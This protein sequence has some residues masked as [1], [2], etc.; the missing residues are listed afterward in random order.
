MS[1]WKVRL[2]KIVYCNVGLQTWWR[3]HQG[4][5]GHIIEI[6]KLNDVLIFFRSILV[7]SGRPQ[8]KTVD[9]RRIGIAW[10]KHCH[11]SVNCHAKSNN[12]NNSYIMVACPSISMSWKSSAVPYIQL[13]MCTGLSYKEGTAVTRFPFMLKSRGL[14]P[15]LLHLC[16]LITQGSKHNCCGIVPSIRTQITCQ[17]SWEP[18]SLCGILEAIHLGLVGSRTTVAQ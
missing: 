18:P 2:V 1:P 3:F 15:G 8:V 5:P 11:K 7:T 9:L 10:L 16:W 4:V 12:Y 13:V 17:K 14:V 6:F